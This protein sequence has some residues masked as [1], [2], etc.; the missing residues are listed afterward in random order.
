MIMDFK[1]LEYLESIYRLR[2]FTK[3]A[4]E[5]YI[6]QPSITNSIRK[7]EEEIGFTLINRED[8]PMTFTPEGEYFMQHVHT[9]LNAVKDAEASME[10]LRGKQSS[11]LNFALASTTSDWLLPKIYSEFQALHKNCTIHIIEDT[12]I[13]ML[14][15]LSD[16]AIDVAYS[17]FPANY[18]MLHYEAI[19]LQQTE[20]CVMCS[21]DHPLAVYERIPIQA[22]EGL[23]ILTF[24][25][26]S[27]IRS[28]FQDECA[29][30][31]VKIELQTVT[32][33]E[34]VRV[35]IDKGYGVTLVTRDHEGQNYAE[36]GTVRPF[37]VPILFTKGFL[38]VRGG[39]RSASVKN[40]MRFITQLVEEERKK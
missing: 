32:Q 31:N 28:T 10:E 33:T 34:V 2:S 24:P 38:L 18:D 4:K 17:L 16:G 12:Y 3:A 23:R 7:L 40:I 36:G 21:D 27:L 8:R 20:L 30:H 11:T 35:L 1:K 37:E 9:I 26:G 13:N 15:G 6:S 14:K 5:C 19:P 25:E 22:L 29:R 39:R